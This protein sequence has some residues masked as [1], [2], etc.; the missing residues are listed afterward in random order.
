MGVVSAFSWLAK[1]APG[2]APVGTR[3]AA[4]IQKFSSGFGSMRIEVRCFIQ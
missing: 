1:R 4:F 2:K 3:Y